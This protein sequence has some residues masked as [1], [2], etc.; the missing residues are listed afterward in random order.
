MMQKPVLKVI[1]FI[2]LS[3]SQITYASSFKPGQTVFVGFPAAN[4]KDDA[5]IVGLV[6]KQLASGNY[7]IT[8]LD[9]VKGHDYGLS[10]V[11]IAEDEHGQ[12]KEVAWDMWTDRKQ[13]Y[14]KGMQYQ[15]PKDHVFK[16]RTGQ[17]NFIERNNLYVSYSR[18]KSNAPIMPLEQFDAMIEKAGSIDLKEVT[19]A[20]ELAKKERQSYYESA[21]GRPFWPYETIVHLNQLTKEI[22][23]ILKADETLTQLWKSQPRNWDAINQ[24]SKYYFLIDAIDKILQDAAYQVTEDGMEKVSPEILSELKNRLTQLGIKY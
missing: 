6:R 16:L 2:M 23:G 3:L 9:Y 10:C 21:Y 12:A 11:P 19:P 22:E 24:S 1:F 8:V 4:S 14:G 18:W 20:L 7:Q 15:V 13:L 17:F 5:Y